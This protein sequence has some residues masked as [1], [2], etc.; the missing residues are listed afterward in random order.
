VKKRGVGTIKLVLQDTR[1]DD[2][3]ARC[4]A[5]E[6][7]VMQLEEKVLKLQ[8]QLEGHAARKH[9]DPKNGPSLPAAPRESD[10]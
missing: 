3:L 4:I 7:R 2:A 8:V 1:I 10:V 6:E 9:R 5:M